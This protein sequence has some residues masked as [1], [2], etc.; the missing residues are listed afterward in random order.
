MGL[1]FDIV[2]DEASKLAKKETKTEIKQRKKEAKL[3]N[4]SSAPRVDQR[5]PDGVSVAVQKRGEGSDLIVTGLREEQLE[6]LLPEVTREIMITVT[7]DRSQFRAAMMRFVREG[8][9]QTIVKVIAGLIVGILLITFG[10]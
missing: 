5:L 6:R 2:G 3:G 8:A 4:T 1:G 9:F 7:E 10:L